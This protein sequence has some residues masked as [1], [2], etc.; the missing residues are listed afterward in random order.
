[1]CNNGQT[2][3]DILSC[4]LCQVKHLCN[5]SSLPAR[6]I[7]SRALPWHFATLA[8]AVW[9]VQTLCMWRKVATSLTL[10]LVLVC[11]LHTHL[12]SMHTRTRSSIKL[13]VTFWGVLE[14]NSIKQHREAMELTIN[15]IFRPWNWQERRC[16]GPEDQRKTG[17]VC[18]YY[19]HNQ[20]PVWRRGRSSL[21]WSTT[22][23]PLS[24]TT[25]AWSILKGWQSSSELLWRELA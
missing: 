16:H 14:P 10:L 13:V 21:L 20:G 11:I 17:A 6:L 12:C 8:M 4:F 19:G 2:G 1:M 9:T 5:T 23:W 3:T 15:C 24:T 7:D 22:S 18:D 25:M